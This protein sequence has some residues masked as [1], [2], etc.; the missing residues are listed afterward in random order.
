MKRS[1]AET[2]SEWE[3]AFELL[4]LVSIITERGD[5]GNRIRTK[6]KGAQIKLKNGNHV[7]E[8]R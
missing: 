4:N 3:Y 1:A 8:A 6:N 5:D 2:Q 7:R